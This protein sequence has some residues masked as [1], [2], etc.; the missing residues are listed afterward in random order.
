MNDQLVK[1]HTLV[2]SCAPTKTIPAFCFLQL[3][4]ETHIELITQVQ[5]ATYLTSV[6]TCFSKQQLQHD[7]SQFEIT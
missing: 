1:S 6:S 4:V 2:P 7:K 5:V 3:N